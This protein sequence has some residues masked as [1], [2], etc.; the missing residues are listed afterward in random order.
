MCNRPS[1]GGL[2]VRKAKD[3]TRRDCRT[4]N[5]VRVQVVM[6]IAGWITTGVRA[7]RDPLIGQ[8]CSGVG[9]PNLGFGPNHRAARPDNGGSEA[10]PLPR[11]G[12]T[13]V[14]GSMVVLAQHD[15]FAF[16]SIGS[17]SLA[18]P[19]SLRYHESMKSVHTKRKEASV[20]CRWEGRVDT[21]RVHQAELYHYTPRAGWSRGELLL[22]GLDAC[23]SGGENAR[24]DPTSHV[25][26]TAS[27]SSKPVS[28]KSSCSLR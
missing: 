25:I 10:S 18:V 21:S 3:F 9:I 1:A 11:N 16:S 28:A 14:I 19:S 27:R 15:T 22:T 24:I 4:W 17:L 23:S 2:H 7:H 12:S 13:S 5:A 8:T 6:T 26:A 20:R